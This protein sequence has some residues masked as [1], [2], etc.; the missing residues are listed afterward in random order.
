MTAYQ[1]FEQKYKTFYNIV[2]W[3][4]FQM[5]YDQLKNMQEFEHLKA[6]PEYQASFTDD[7][8]FL[9]QVANDIINYI[10]NNWLYEMCRKPTYERDDIVN[11]L[12]ICGNTDDKMIE[13]YYNM[14][15]DKIV[16]EFYYQNC[17]YEPEQLDQMIP[18]YSAPEF[19]RERI[20]LK[21]MKKLRAL[22]PRGELWEVQIRS[23]E[24]IVN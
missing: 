18:Y 7:H 19:N 14:V 10:K 23:L 4:T 24:E 21:Y 15:E 22:K 5:V 17:V 8:L 6:T 12:D 1:L 20:M 9:E 2:P 11:L 16:E 13:R 3:P